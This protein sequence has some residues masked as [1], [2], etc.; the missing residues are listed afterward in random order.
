M[1]KLI[2]AM[3]VLAV[4]ACFTTNTR[5][6]SIAEDVAKAQ[7]LSASGDN[8]GALAAYESLI[9]AHPDSQGV[10]A[11][12][13]QISW[14]YWQMNKYTEC[15]AAREKAIELTTDPHAKRDWQFEGAEWCAMWLAA[16]IKRYR[17]LR[18]L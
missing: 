1:G 11:W 16:M 2:R 17:L 5:A 10:P 6:A 12:Y 3:I 9:A 14:C 15:F 8:K 18:S 13:Y 7:A 4:C